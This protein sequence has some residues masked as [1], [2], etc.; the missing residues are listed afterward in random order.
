MA[1]ACGPGARSSRL[2]RTRWSLRYRK[3]SRFQSQQPWTCQRP[4]APWQPKARSAAHERA[5]DASWSITSVTAEARHIVKMTRVS[6]PVAPDDP[7]RVVVQDTPSH[8]VDAGAAWGTLIH[9]LL[10]H[11]MRFEHA[12][13]E[14]L[15]RLAV[16]L[17]MEEPK[18]RTV[19]DEALDTVER[20]R[21]ADFWK[22]AQSNE[23][24]VETPFMVANGR[25]LRAG[26][27]DLIHRDGDAWVITDYKTDVDASVEAAKVY[28]LQLES[29]KKALIACGLDVK[30][31]EIASVRRS[32]G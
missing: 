29:Y 31:A 28:A 11:A 12:T 24:S 15:R 16:W 32:D 10:E 19:I 25:D 20:V 14:D 6:E 17:S 4:L 13:R 5:K 23:H 18:L 26:V 9:G 30:A 8:R 1:V 3:R 27:I 21:R 7:T 2:S 22:A